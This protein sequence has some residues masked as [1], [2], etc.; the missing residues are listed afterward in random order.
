MALLFLGDSITQ[1]WDEYSYKKFFGLYDPV[2]L[3]I[4]GHT[5]KDTLEL[6]Q[7]TG[8]H[9]LKP[10]VVVLQIGTNN[11]DNGI[12]TGETL[13][14]IKRIINN[15]LKLSSQTRILLIG[16]LPRGLSESDKYRVFNVQVNKLLS[17]EKFPDYVFYVDLSDIFLRSDKS[18]CKSIMYDYLHLTPKGY[19]DLS[20]SISSFL[21]IL[22]SHTP[23]TLGKSG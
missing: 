22:F 17:E 5:T 9:K 15:I 10:N 2:N 16:P 20:E 7:L 3:G 6:I 19:K 11:A 4:S 8:L 18:I 21:F 12:T 23:T 1:W 14:D 13:S